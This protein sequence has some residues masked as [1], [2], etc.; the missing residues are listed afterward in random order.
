MSFMINR[1]GKK[2]ELQVVPDGEYTAEITDV[3]ADLSNDKACYVSFTLLTGEV[4]R[5]RYVSNPKKR[6]PL[7]ILINVTLGRRSINV[8]LEEIIGKFVK[9]TV[10]NEQIYTNVKKVNKLNQQDIEEL[11]RHLKDE[12]T[13]E[14]EESDE[15]DDDEVLDTEELDLESWD[16]A[17]EDTESDTDEPHKIWMQ[18]ESRRKRR[19]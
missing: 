11:E 14:I 17:Y 19:I 7:D 6:D 2:A 9:I 8:D 5:N 1:E 3:E 10:A 12:D 16:D 18:P 15:L 13:D 4:I